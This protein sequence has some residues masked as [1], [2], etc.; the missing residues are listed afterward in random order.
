MKKGLPLLVC[1]AIAA[2]AQAPGPSLP[3]PA[4]TTSPT[5]LGLNASRLS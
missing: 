4:F 2:T 3:R 1:L 5:L